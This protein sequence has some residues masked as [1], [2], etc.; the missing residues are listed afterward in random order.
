VHASSDQLKQRKRHAQAQARDKD[1]PKLTFRTITLAFEA[2]EAPI[3]TMQRIWKRFQKSITVEAQRLYGNLPK[4]MSS[5]RAPYA[6]SKTSRLFAGLAKAYA[7]ALTGLVQDKELAALDF[8]NW[9]HQRSKVTVYWTGLVAK[10]K[11]TARKKPAAQGTLAPKR[12][13]AAKTKRKSTVK[14]KRKGAVE[15]KRKSAAKV[16]HVVAPARVD[17]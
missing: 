3:E 7:A 13:P 11:R 5:N 1:M 15:T 10:K 12:K 8:E 14:T 9:L 4:K 16:E 6:V 17:S 2:N